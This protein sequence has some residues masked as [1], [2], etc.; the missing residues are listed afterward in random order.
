MVSQGNLG[1]MRLDCRRGSVPGGYLTKSA[2]KNKTGVIRMTRQISLER[3]H[4][5]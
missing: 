3:V 5:L 4:L 2:I 1:R